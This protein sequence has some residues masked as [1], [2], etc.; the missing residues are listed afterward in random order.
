MDGPTCTKAIESSKISKDTQNPSHITRMLVQERGKVE[1]HIHLLWVYA[2]VNIHACIKLKSKLHRIFFLFFH[3]K[4]TTLIIW[5]LDKLKLSKLKTRGCTLPPAWHNVQKPFHPQ[6]CHYSVN[7]R[8]RVC[9][10]SP[11]F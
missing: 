6:S 9:L 4:E 1:R 2:Y 8:I 11:P 7:S 10:D 3:L 5:G